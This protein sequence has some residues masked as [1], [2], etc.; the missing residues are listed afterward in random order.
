M[1]LDLLVLLI[2]KSW[3][4][5]TSKGHSQE[6]K[7]VEKQQQKLLVDSALHIEISLKGTQFGVGIKLDANVNFEGFPIEKCMKFGLV[8]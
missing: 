5:G 7:V 2:S 8:M 3:R 4:F 6:N 1:L